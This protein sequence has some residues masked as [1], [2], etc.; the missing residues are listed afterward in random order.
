MLELSDLLG[1]FRLDFFVAF[2]SEMNESE[3]GIFE[4]EMNESERGIVICNVEL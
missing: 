4:S 3:R 1:L 2:E